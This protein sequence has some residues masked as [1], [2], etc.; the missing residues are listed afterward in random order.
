MCKSAPPPPTPT[1][2]VADKIQNSTNVDN[3]W[4]FVNLHLPSTIT[5][6]VVQ[7]ITPPDDFRPNYT[8]SAH[9]GIDPLAHPDIIYV[10]YPDINSSTDYDPSDTGH[11]GADE[12]SGST[13][14]LYY[15]DS[16]SSKGAIPPHSSFPLNIAIWTQEETLLYE[17]PSGPW[18]QCN[19]ELS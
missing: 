5:T 1:T 8:L 2:E 6:A 15:A 14:K 16:N 19:Y 12:S 3:S 4:S 7:Q 11:G 13:T 18:Q 10:A 9:L 17:V